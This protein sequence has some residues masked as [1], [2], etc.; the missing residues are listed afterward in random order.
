MVRT[1][2]IEPARAS[3]RD[4]KSLASTSFATSAGFAEAA[5]YLPE[6]GS[7]RK[8]DGDRE[9]TQVANG[10]RGALKPAPGAFAP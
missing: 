3:P 7:G 5:I 10:A 9:S 8:A 6:G 4:F 2:G 1:A